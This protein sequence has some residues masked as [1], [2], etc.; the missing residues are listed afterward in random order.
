MFFSTGEAKTAEMKHDLEVLQYKAVKAH[1]SN[2][3]LANVSQLLRVT[4]MRVRS[5][6]Y[7]NSITST[8]TRT[9][10]TNQLQF[11]EHFVYQNYL[12]GGSVAEWLA[13][14][15]QAQKRRVQIAVATLSGNSLGQTAHTH[16]ASVSPGL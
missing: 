16:C 3:K 15:T 2:H 6:S 5:V 10:W 4:K 7:G 11:V 9:C 14:W 12:R 8:Y 1:H 13:C